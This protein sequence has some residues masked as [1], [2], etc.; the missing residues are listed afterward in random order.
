MNCWTCGMTTEN[1]K[2][3]KLENWQTW[4]A[5]NGK[6]KFQLCER[7]AVVVERAIFS[8]LL[9]TKEVCKEPGKWKMFWARVFND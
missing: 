1:P 8:R 2:A 3:G 5:R 4:N 9:V 7:C 6:D